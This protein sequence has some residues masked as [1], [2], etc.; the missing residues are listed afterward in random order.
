[1][2]FIQIPFKMTVQ[3]E[4]C[5]GHFQWDGFHYH[6]KLHQNTEKGQIDRALEPEKLE[7]EEMARIVEEVFPSGFGSREA[8]NFEDHWELNIRI[9][10]DDDFANAMLSQSNAEER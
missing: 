4:E 5:N 10:Y 7:P 9:A 2:I 8:L 1:M 6:G 3:I